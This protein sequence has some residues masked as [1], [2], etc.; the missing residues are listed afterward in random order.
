MSTT[1]SRR[2]ALR[3][4]PP[5]TPS[6]SPGASSCHPRRNSGDLQA[7]NRFM[8]SFVERPGS[9][10]RDR[11]VRR[12]FLCLR[13]RREPVALRVSRLSA[14]G[15]C[16]GG[17]KRQARRLR[18]RQGAAPCD[19][20]GVPGSEPGRP[21]RPGRLSGLVGAAGSRRK[22]RRGGPDEFR[23]PRVWRR[24]AVAPIRGAGRQRPARMMR[25]VAHHL[26]RRKS[27][28][29]HRF[30]GCA[31]MRQTAWRPEDFS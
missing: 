22:R 9:R 8:N 24:S 6:A 10:R 14:G 20:R 21:G 11:A 7:R 15:G 2:A 23:K 3:G 30:S 1:R 29:D 25:Q 5:S 26:A 18:T 19:P 28:A 31:S 13:F 4:T 16:N 27:L 17:R 12:E